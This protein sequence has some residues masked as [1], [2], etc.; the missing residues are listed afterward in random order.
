[1]QIDGVFIAK[2][3]GIET[4]FVLEAKAGRGL[5][6]LAKH[7]LVYPYLALRSHVPDYMPITPV[8]LRAV[9]ESGELHFY[10]A[11]CTVA[12]DRGQQVAISSLE[13]TSVG[14]YVVRGFGDR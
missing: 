3:H 14:H 12:S 7:K 13:A 10:V 8:Y 6:S 11:T 4:L 1:V 2:R 9:R 5:D